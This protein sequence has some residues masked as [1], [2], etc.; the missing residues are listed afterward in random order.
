MLTE[1]ERELE[2]LRRRYFEKLEVDE[3]G[4]KFWGRRGYIDGA[5]GQ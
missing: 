1:C 3:A 5:F 2:D 4:V